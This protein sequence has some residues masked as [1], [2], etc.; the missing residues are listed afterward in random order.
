[1]PIL[2]FVLHFH[3]QILCTGLLAPIDLHQTIG[4]RAKL[5]TPCRLCGWGSIIAKLILLVVVAVKEEI[6]GEK[7]RRKRK[8]KRRRR[9]VEKESRGRRIWR[10]RNREKKRRG[11]RRRQRSERERRG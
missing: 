8:G 7:I 10:K 6:K 9:R 2:T 1:M 4:C 3:E 11:Q 5:K